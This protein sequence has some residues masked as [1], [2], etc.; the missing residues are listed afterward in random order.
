MLINYLRIALRNLRRQPGYAAINVLGLG[1]GMAAC[2]LIGLFVWQEITYD[3]FH[4]NSDRLYRAWIEHTTEDRG[5]VFEIV[6]PIVLGPALEEAFPEVEA[7]V[8][9]REEQEIM[10]GFDERRF[11]ETVHAVDPAFFHAFTFPLLQGD[12][13]TALAGSGRV[14]L[15][16]E[17]ADRYFPDANPMGQVLPLTMG[18]QL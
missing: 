15:S 3:R 11:T 18:G 1:A 9:V 2:L 8:R 10:V 7:I 6:T 14:V 17:M 12:P 5:T 4:E 13:A 16:Q